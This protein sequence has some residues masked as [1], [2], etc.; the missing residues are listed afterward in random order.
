MFLPLSLPK[1]PQDYDF[2]KEFLE[3]PESVG[4]T[5]SGIWGPADWNSAGLKLLPGL[6]S[7]LYSPTPEKEKE[8]QSGLHALNPGQVFDQTI[9]VRHI[10]YTLWPTFQERL[11]SYIRRKIT[12]LCPRLVRSSVSKENYD[13]LDELLT[14]IHQVGGSSSAGAAT[15]DDLITIL[16][17]YN[18]YAGNQE[19]SN[20]GILEIPK[21]LEV[22]KPPVVIADGLAMLVLDRETIDKKDERGLMFKWKHVPKKCWQEKLARYIA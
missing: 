3:K 7:P 13:P 15:D 9:F 20:L 12:A 22:L 14:Y 6:N 4:L 10:K 2:V 18:E 16:K 17:L 11:S 19:D 5:T 21:V 8:L 1:N